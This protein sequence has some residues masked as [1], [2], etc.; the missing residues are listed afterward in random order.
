M[1][2]HFIPYFPCCNILPLSKQ[3]H[4]SRLINRRLWTFGS[5]TLRALLLKGSDRWTSHRRTT[6]IH[7]YNRK[8]VHRGCNFFLSK[9]TP[10]QC[11]HFVCLRELCVQ[12]VSNRVSSF[13]PVTL[14]PISWGKL[15]NFLKGHWTRTGTPRV[16]FTKVGTIMV[17]VFSWSGEHTFQKERALHSELSDGSTFKSDGPGNFFLPS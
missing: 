5:R 12:V 15:L 11:P 9:P 10:V 16:I 1:C 13:L 14:S 8:Q 17:I 7:C 6:R 3:S 2:V 4:S